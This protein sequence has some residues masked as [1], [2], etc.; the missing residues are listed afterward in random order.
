MVGQ[1]HFGNKI[2]WKF[3]RNYARNRNPP[4]TSVKVT[5][6]KLHKKFF[7][8]SISVGQCGNGIL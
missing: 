4:G 3:F 5:L 1:N 8:N 7:Q 2:P 6:K